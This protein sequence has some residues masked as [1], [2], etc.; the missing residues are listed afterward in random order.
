M[1]LSLAVRAASAPPSPWPLPTRA[2]I[3]ISYE[4]AE[5]RARQ[6]V[7]AIEAKGRR[8]QGRQCRAVRDISGAM[9]FSSTGLF[10]DK[11]AIK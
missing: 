9:L 7:Q 5:D 3:A 1:R 6:M 2:R 11:M 8:N 10:S 4:R